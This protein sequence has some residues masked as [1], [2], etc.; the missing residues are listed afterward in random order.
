MAK[1]FTSLSENQRLAVGTPCK[2]CATGVYKERSG[3]FGPFVSCSRFPACDAKVMRP[4]G[5]HVPSDTAPNEVEAPASVTPVMEAPIAPVPMSTQPTESP[6]MPTPSSL[7]VQI[8]A[9]VQPSINSA[10]AKVE[11]DAG[12]VLALV[13]SE[14]AKLSNAA[15][16]VIEVKREDQPTRMIEGAHYLMPRLLKLLS[17]GFHVFCWGPPGSGKS[18]AQMQALTALGMGYEID[19][20]DQTTMRSQVQ[21]FCRPDGSKQHTS[22]T[23]CWEGDDAYPEGKGYIA[24][25][26]GNSPANIQN[27]YN[28]AL[29]NGHAALAWGNV[30]RRPKFLFCGNDNTP[31]RPTRQFPDRKPMSGAFLDR[32]YFMH[33]PIDLNIMRGACGMAPMAAPIRDEFSCSSAQWGSFVENL[34]AW[35]VVNAPTLNVSPRAGISGVKALA[36]GETPTEIAHALIFRGADNELVSKAL[37]AVALP[38]ES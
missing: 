11:V 12:K 5:F 22:F 9:L 26:A 14:V 34:M 32:L 28:S 38:R 17:A 1:I 18:T 15:P 31:G 25:E 20:L 6:V 23:R 36:C 8:L 19:T 7:E 16:L 35:A 4:R 10:L 24:E 29:A 13:Q 3:K 2:E 37:T 30:A 33:W 27:L 21:G